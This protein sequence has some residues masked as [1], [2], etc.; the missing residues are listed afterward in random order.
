MS[1]I[2]VSKEITLPASENPYVIIPATFLSGDESNFILSLK[3]NNAIEALP[4]SNEHEWPSVEVLI[5]L[6]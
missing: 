1:Y 2:L 5:R 3:S 4:I 6:K